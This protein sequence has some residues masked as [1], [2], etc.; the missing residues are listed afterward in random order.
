MRFCR[1][2][3]NS[4]VVFVASKMSFPFSEFLSTFY[5]LQ[6]FDI[7]PCTGGIVNVT[8]R[9]RKI[10]PNPQGAPGVDQYF[11]GHRSVILKYAPPYVA[12]VGEGAPMDQKRQVRRPA[13]CTSNFTFERMAKYGLSLSKS[14]RNRNPSPYLLATSPFKLSSSC[15]AKP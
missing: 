4:H 13:L 11:D 5:R 7:T 15:L 3:F 2:K 8:V 9:A 12:G 10:P 1:N 14:L 6:A